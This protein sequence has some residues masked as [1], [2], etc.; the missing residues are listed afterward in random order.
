MVKIGWEVVRMLAAFWKP[1]F[2]RILDHLKRVAV[3][4]LMFCNTS[5]KSQSKTLKSQFKETSRSL[6]GS[7]KWGPPKEDEFKSLYSLQS[8]PMFMRYPFSPSVNFWNEILKMSSWPELGEAHK[9]HVKSY[10]RWIGPIGIGLPSNG[11]SG[12]LSQTKIM[13][14]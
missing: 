1:Y 7:K 9:G 14:I 3:S 2:I 13:R 6:H 10:V 8:G 4:C 12:H 11:F 5:L